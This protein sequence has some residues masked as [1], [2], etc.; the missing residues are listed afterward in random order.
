MI[1]SDLAEDLAITCGRTLLEMLPGDYDTYTKS[2]FSDLVTEADLKCQQ[3]ITDAILH[4]FPDDGVLAE[5]EFNRDSDSGWIWIVDPLDGT[6]NFAHHM[7]FFCVSIACYFKDRAEIGVINAP[8]Q[9]E[10]FKTIKG[11]GVRMNGRPVSV[12]NRESLAVSMMATGFPYDRHISKDDNIS[13]FINFTKRT[14]AV[15]RFGSAALDLAYVACGRL[16]GYW[17]LKLKPWDVAAGVMMVEEAGGKV[18]GY[19]GEPYSIYSPLIVASN[20]LIHDSILKILEL[21]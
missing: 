18:T 16:D 9:R 5:E 10:F 1:R 14:H 11:Q 7:P 21:Q 19:K 6:T 15:R 4:H 20:T 8:Y 2:S 12:S 13:H 17:E 3:F